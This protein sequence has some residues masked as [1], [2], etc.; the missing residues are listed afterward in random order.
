MDSGG[1]GAECQA[2]ASDAEHVPGLGRMESGRIRTH[3]RDGGWL[4]GIRQYIP[5]V[6]P[7]PSNRPISGGLR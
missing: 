7:T 1:I 6:G 2:G 5:D 3:E 4:G